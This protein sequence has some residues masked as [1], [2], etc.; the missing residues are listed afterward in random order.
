[1]MKFRLPGALHQGAFLPGRQDAKV[2]LG[3]ECYCSPPP[4]LPLLPRAPHSDCPR[5]RHILVYARRRR[6]NLVPSASRQEEGL[7]DSGWAAAVV[8]A[9]VA[10]AVFLPGPC[11]LNMHKTESILINIII[12]FNNYSS[13]TGPHRRASAT[14]W[15]SE[16]AA[17]AS[18][19]IHN[20]EALRYHVQ[21]VAG[22]DV[23]ACINM[24][25][26]Q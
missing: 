9:A 24:K 18:L 4:S 5:R 25:K 20:S 7:H 23:P 1:M 2:L 15:R 6:P 19:T 14:I 16:A 8:V 17:L 3:E 12:L 10:A 21:Q 26:T 11:S 22:V 13:V